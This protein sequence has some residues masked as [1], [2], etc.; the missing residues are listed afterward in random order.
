MTWILVFTF[1]CGDDLVGVDVIP[2]SENTSPMQVAAMVVI[3]PEGSELAVV[4]LSA[5][6]V[7]DLKWIEVF[8]L[9]G[10]NGQDN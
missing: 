4:S 6:E 5:L 1:Y 2:A 7:D 8:E 9:R 10:I 3:A